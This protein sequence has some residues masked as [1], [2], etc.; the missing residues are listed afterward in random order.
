VAKGFLK[1][2]VVAS[3]SVGLMSVVVGSKAKNNRLSK[4]HYF[5]K[6]FIQPPD[7]PVVKKEDLRYKFN[8]NNGSQANYDDKNGLYLGNPSNIVTE[9]QYNPKTG[10]YDITQKIGKMNYRPET[11]VEFQ[12]YQEELFKQAVKNHWKSKIKAEDL[13][14][15]NKKSLLPKLQVNN[16]IFDRIF[17]GNNVE[18]KPTGT[19][20]LIFALNRNKTL[21]PAIPQRNQKVTNF[22]FNMRIQ[23]NLLGKIGD[24][25]KITTSYNTE[26]SFDWENQMRLEYTGYEDEIIKKIEAGNVSLPLNSS[27]IT[28]SQTLF[29]VK[30]Q[31]QFGR[32]MA[33]ALFSQQKGKKQEVS[34]Q[35]GAQ[36][37]Y[38]SVGADNYE[39]NK[40]YFLGHYF[41]DNYDQWMATLPIVATPIIITKAEVYI[42]NQ[43]GGTEQ[44]RSIA[45]FTD[46][47]E[48]SAHVN[49][50]LNNYNGNFNCQLGSSYV[51]VDSADVNPH[52][53]A[54]S[55]YHILTN[56]VD[57]L[58]AQRSTTFQAVNA[59][60]QSNI[61]AP[62]TCNPNNQFMVASR[63]FEYVSN[64]R[65]LN[66][67]EFTINN[68]LGFISINQTIN[69]DVTVAV[70]Y[71]YTYNGKNIS[72]G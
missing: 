43:T 16:E 36:T 41:R 72:S 33:T 32:L 61:S 28:G 63:D 44:V 8:D 20:E 51:I 38:F 6:N 24:K 2:V 12:D 68:R 18:I 55:L 53:G 23:L 3:T 37:Q 52:N 1:F 22:D 40:H 70:A 5:Y 9:T 14:N 69:N 46:L 57:G 30:T 45:A 42:T 66:P 60:L 39:V 15:Q 7:T 13:N 26:A 49:P 35:G 67:T 11:Y 65:K 47:G 58:I 17:G 54:N 4:P 59:T 19:A 34:L 62:N 50:A 21:N 64:A 25:L 71:Q 48:D 31:L 29:G 10:N 27:L 56:S